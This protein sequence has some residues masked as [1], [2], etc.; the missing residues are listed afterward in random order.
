VVEVAPEPVAEAP[1]KPAA[2]VKPLARAAS[3]VAGKAVASKPVAA[4][5]PT[6]EGAAREM[7][8]AKPPKKK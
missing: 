1:Q 3:K 7:A 6:V 5:F 8:A 2:K 4:P